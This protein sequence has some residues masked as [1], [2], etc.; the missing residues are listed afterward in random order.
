MCGN[1]AKHSWGRVRRIMYKYMRMHVCMCMHVCMHVYLMNII[2]ATVTRLL[3][4]G[5]ARLR[6]A[7]AAHKEFFFNL[8][9][10]Q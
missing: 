1:S 3:W 10:K 6:E 4:R 9:V 2:S 7:L 5:K 8:A